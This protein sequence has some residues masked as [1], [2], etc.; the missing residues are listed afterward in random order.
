MK[1]RKL[2][3]SVIGSSAT[4]LDGNFDPMKDGERRVFIIDKRAKPNCKLIENK[5]TVRKFVPKDAASS[6]CSSSSD[7]ERSGRKFAP[8]DCI[9]FEVVNYEEDAK[10]WCQPG[11][12][13]LL[14]ANKKTENCGVGKILAKL[15]LNEDT[16]H[17]VNSDENESVKDIKKWIDECKNQKTCKESEYLNKLINLQKWMNSECKKLLGLVIS[18][19]D[20]AKAHV[21]F[22]SA[23]EIGYSQM[24]IKLDINK[25]YPEDECLSVDVLKSRYNGDGKMVDGD[26][27]IDVYNK[28]WFFCRPKTQAS[29]DACKN[30]IS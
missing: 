7:D 27:T 15:C 28:D 9:K 18:A 2:I 22:N 5:I 11:Y 8:E 1:N 25:M 21:Y 19:T 24:F 30:Y 20:K 4:F 17:N 26:K 23:I 13:Y 29:Q 6:S 10:I 12:I 14:T 16:M 3:I